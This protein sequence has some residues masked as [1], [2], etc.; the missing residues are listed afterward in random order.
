MPFPILGTPKP[1]F[2]DSSG[3]PLASGTLT[4]QE[5]ADD[6]NKASYPTY[7]DAVALTNANTNPLTLDSRGETTDGLWGLDGE[8]YKVVLKDSDGATLWTQD[9]IMGSRHYQVTAAET[10]AGV[11]PND[12]SYPPGDVRRYGADPTG[13]A[14]STTAFDNAFL[15]AE[16]GANSVYAPGGTYNVTDLAFRSNVF[17]YGDGPEVTILRHHAL[18]GV[19]VL[20]HNDT[21]I[22]NIG[23]SDLTIDGNKSLGTFTGAGH[24]IDLRDASQIWFDNI[25]VRDTSGHGFQLADVQYVMGGKVR[26]KDCEKY[27][28]VIDSE[29]SATT[30]TQYINIDTIHVTGSGI[31]ASGWAGINIGDVFP[32]APRGPRYLNFGTLYAE[33]CGNASASAGPGVALGRNAATGTTGP[34]YVQIGNLIS[35]DNETFGVELFGCKQVTIGEIIAIGNDKHGV[36]FSYGDAAG[37][38]PD[39]P[40]LCERV[41]VGSILSYSNGFDGVRFGGCEEA[42]VGGITAMNNDSTGGGYAGVAFEP[43]G[44]SAI[45]D[46][47]GNGNIVIGQVYV[48][49]D[50]GSPTQTYGISYGDGADPKNSAYIGSLIC[51]NNK[52]DDI[53]TEHTGAVIASVLK[54]GQ[55]KADTWEQDFADNADGGGHLS[56]QLE[57]DRWQMKRGQ[58]TDAT[59]RTLHRVYVPANTFGTLEVIVNAVESGNLSG[60]RASYRFTAAVVNTGSATNVVGSVTANHTVEGTGSMDCTVT[61]G[62]AS[63]AYVNVRITGVAATTI[64][65][66]CRARV[67]ANNSL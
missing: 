37:S 49:D 10:A 38:P 36:T 16:Q 7:D 21:D 35:R 3:S 32:S 61:S 53:N 41:S 34:Q 9:D 46:G 5:P 50:Q 58:T 15:V 6:T 28:F 8:D 62:G 17:L 31:E 52:T 47:Y 1:Q 26:V 18:T 65:W 64:N 54:V 24:G 44:G 27:G 67:T 2:F 4:I 25:L 12:Y 42:N 57:V 63:A 13:V 23:F 48:G 59:V 22:T 19:Y 55:L 43:G 39:S 66:D 56:T 40:V 11:T 29:S 60:E 45:T 51:N 14:N 20:G 30:Y 33:E